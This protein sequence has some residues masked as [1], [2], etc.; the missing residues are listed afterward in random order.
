M[1]PCFQATKACYVAIPNVL[2]GQLNCVWRKSQQLP[3][4]RSTEDSPGWLSQGRQEFHSVQLKHLGS[5]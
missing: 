1:P 2:T 5:R 4:A 3:S